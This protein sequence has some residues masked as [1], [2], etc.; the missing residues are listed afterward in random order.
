VFFEEYRFNPGGYIHA[1]CAQS[2]FETTDLLERIRRFSPQLDEAELVEL[3]AAL[4]AT[5]VTPSEK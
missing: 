2:Y 5:R 1:Q 4:A 3:A